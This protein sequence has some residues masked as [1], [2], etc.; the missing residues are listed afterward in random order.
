LVLTGLLSQGGCRFSYEILSSEEDLNLG[1]SVGD[2]DGDAQPGDGDGDGDIQPG[3]GDGD[4][5]TQPGDGDGDG[6][7]D[8]GGIGG[9]ETGGTGGTSGGGAGGTGGG[10]T[11]SG[12]TGG[13][14]TGG[15]PPIVELVVDTTLDEADAGASPGNPGGAGFSLREAIG[16]ANTEPGAQH[17]TFSVPGNLTLTQG[18]LPTVTGPLHLEGSAVIDA[19]GTNASEACLKV[20]SSDVTVQ[21]IEL[22]GCN[23]EPIITATTSGPNVLVT[24]CA[25]HD[26]AQA[27]HFAG[28]APQIIYNS[29]FSSGGAG[30]VVFG[31]G[32]QFVANLVAFS[33]GPAVYLDG[34]VDDVL[35]L[36]NISYSNFIGIELLDASNVRVWFN[37]L[38]QSGWLGMRL[39]TASNVDFRN[40]I[41]T[42]TFA[43]GV[44]G[45]AAQFSE[46]DYNLFYSTGLEDFNF[47]AIGPNSMT[48][49]D[50]L[51]T[52]PGAFDFTL[53]SGSPA[54]DAGFDL[55]EDRNL[56][57]PG[58]FNGVAP[59]LGAIEAP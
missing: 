44:E 42:N 35:L 41:I 11:D 56:G 12:G 46:R 52:N 28:D 4:G 51:Y 58:L 10:G 21:N 14:G 50:P 25:L 3:D 17:I 33:N 57:A 38:D 26:N 43:D 7:G 30:A 55:N 40:N 9:M 19:S 39:V 32:A 53:Q 49:T 15:A 18:D 54:I 34:G 27:A 1:G 22:F 36:A 45:S 8:T 47:G 2:G 5:D 16:F 24:G 23:V 29:I 6:D 59:D 20:D 48:A 37:T 13:G 31:D